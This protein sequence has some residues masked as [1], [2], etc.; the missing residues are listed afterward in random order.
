MVTADL[1]GGPAECTQR[2][3]L[4]ITVSSV[5]EGEVVR[6]DRER[7]ERLLARIGTGDAG[8]LGELY[9]AYGRIV[10]AVIY[11]MLADPEAAEEVAQDVFHSVWRRAKGYDTARGAVRTWVLAIARNAAIDWQRTRGKRAQ[12]EVDLDAAADLPA[13]ASVE[14]QVIAGLRAERIQQAVRALPAEQRDVLALAF[15]GG[16]TQTEIARRTGTPLGTVKSRVRLGMEKLRQQLK[17]AGS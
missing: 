4:R 17:E 5:R 7:D 3:S 8:A 13:D 2:A 1:L 9:D 11:R 10:F 6:R 14:G 15:W 12:R 16:L